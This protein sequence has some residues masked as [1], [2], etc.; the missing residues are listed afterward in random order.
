MR[1][2]KDLARSPALLFTG[3]LQSFSAPVFLT[4]SF[5]ERPPAGRMA[6][7]LNLVALAGAGRHW[8]H[9]P[10]VLVLNDVFH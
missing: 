9:K 8:L 6:A 7:Q 5:L 10:A 4:L 1:T 3:A 2:A